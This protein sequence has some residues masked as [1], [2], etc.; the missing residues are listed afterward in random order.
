MVLINKKTKLSLLP[1][2]GSESH[3]V[4]HIKDLPRAEAL[5]AHQFTS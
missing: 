4:P 2:R 5:R 1:L 3:D